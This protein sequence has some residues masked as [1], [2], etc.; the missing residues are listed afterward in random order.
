MSPRSRA[1]RTPKRPAEAGD[2][3]EGERSAAG[4]LLHRMGLQPR[5]GLGQHFLV[6]PG[7]LERI[8]DAGD[9]GPDD[10]VVEIGPGLGALTEVL[11]RKAGSV[12]ALE[13]DD[14]LA[15]ALKGVFADQPHVSIHH[16][17][18]MKTDIATLVPDSKPYKLV[19]NLPYYVAT[20]I[21]RRFLEAD[22][23]PSV[24]VVTV[25]REVAQSM[26]APE[27]KTGLLGVATRFY[28]NPKIVSLVKPGSFY[29]PPKVTSAVL[30]IDVHPSPPVQ[31]PSEAGFFTLVRAGFSAPR[32]QLKGVLSHA[33]KAPVGEV[34]GALL[35]A[36]VDPT[37]RAETLT[38]EEWAALHRAGEV[39]GWRL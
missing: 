27:G 38:L 36:G 4:R 28:G 6:S 30:R 34:E 16:G 19:A 20:A 18:A 15:E 7:V 23:K 1:V 3:P 33:L 11:A 13:L 10:T 12:V 26:S 24:I 35:T 32:K 21:V 31:V 5:K 9:V 17:D 39:A 25:Q 2:T 37:R 22:H 8:A 29:P 14:E